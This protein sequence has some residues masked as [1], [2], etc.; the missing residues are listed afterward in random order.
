[1]EN[2]SESDTLWPTVQLLCGLSQIENFLLMLQSSN[3]FLSFFYKHIFPLIF[4][5]MFICV[6]CIR[7]RRRTARCE[8]RHQNSFTYSHEKLRSLSC[9]AGAAIEAKNK[10]NWPFWHSTQSLSMYLL[11]SLQTAENEFGYNQYSYQKK[12]QNAK[13]EL[14][15]HFGHEF[16]TIFSCDCDFQ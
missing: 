9:C 7:Q 4:W 15:Q 12:I 11:M 14:P 8:L 6:Y 5:A 1:M 13:S 16:C 3:F 2:F 10:K